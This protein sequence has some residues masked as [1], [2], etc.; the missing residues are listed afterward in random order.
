MEQGGRR[1]GGRERED[2]VSAGQTGNIYLQHTVDM[3]RYTQ[4]VVFLIFW[5][6]LFPHL[7]DACTTGT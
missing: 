7:V 4:N 2:T 3:D 5:V 6:L 1:E